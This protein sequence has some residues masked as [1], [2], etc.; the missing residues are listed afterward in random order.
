MSQNAIEVL[1]AVGASCFLVCQRNDEGDA[2]MLAVHDIRTPDTP[3]FIFALD[4]E[5]LKRLNDL[6]GEAL[7]RPGMNI[8]EYAVFRASGQLPAWAAAQTGAMSQ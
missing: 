1:K 4:D 5:A 7:F 2:L 6:A 3:L 8:K